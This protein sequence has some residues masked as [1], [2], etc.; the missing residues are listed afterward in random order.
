MACILGMSR[1][2]HGEAGTALVSPKH[3][4]LRLIHCFPAFFTP[5]EFN[6]LAVMTILLRAP[7]LE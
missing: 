6:D 4:V 2:L 7:A 5:T 1:D 3:R